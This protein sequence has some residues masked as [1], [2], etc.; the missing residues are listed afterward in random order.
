MLHYNYTITRTWR[1]TDV[2]GNYSECDQII[3]V[4]DITKPVITCPAPVTVNCQD[5]HTSASTGVATA[6]DNCAG[7][8]NIAITQSDVSTQ[9]ADINSAGHYNYTITR[10]WRA[11]DVAGNYSECDQ[12]IKVQ[13][14]TKPV[15]ITTPSNVLTNNDA[16]ICGAVVSFAATASDNC[17]PVAITYSKNPGTVF[18]VGTTS[19][20][21]TATDVSG[22]VLTATFEVTVTDNEKP[23]IITVNKIQ[24][25][26]VGDCG[27]FV[28]V[29]VPVTGDNCQV[30]TLVNNYNS[31]SNAS[32]H[33]PVGTTTINWTVT[34]IHGNINTAT[35]TVIVNDT[36]K[37]I[38]KAPGAYSVPSDPGLCGA[39]IASIGTPVTSDNC[40]VASITNNH[41]STF[42]PVGTTIVIWTV[43]DIHGN[44]TDTATQRIRVIDN[45]L[46]KITV[47]N[48]SVNSDLNV[49]GATIQPATPVTSDNCGV[50]TV[51]SDHP[52]TFYPVGTTLV[53]WTVTDIHGLHASVVQTIIVVDRQAP[54]AI[55]KNITVNLDGAGKVT[56]AAADVNNGSND[57]CG[58][59]SMTVSPSMFSCS[60]IGNNTVTLTVTDVNGNVSYK[61]AV[62]TVQDKLGPVPTLTTLPTV[63]GQCSARIL[64]ANNW[65]WWYSGDDDDD[66]DDSYFGYYLMN[67][68]TATDNCSG[69]IRG[70]TTDPLNYYV[71]GT[72]TIHWKFTDSYGNTTI[73]EQTVIVKDNQAP[74]PWLTSLP[75]VTGQC[76]VDLSNGYDGDDDDYEEDHD[77]D[78]EGDNDH[79]HWNKHHS[80]APWAWDNCAGWIRGTTTDPLTYATQGTYIIH[81]KFDDGHGNI[82]IQN[83]T[84]IVKDVTAPKAIVKNLP[85]ISGQC[86]VTVTTIPTAKDDCIGIVNGTTTSPLTYSAQGTYTIV[87]K[88]TDGRG[89][90]STQNQTVV[91]DDDNTAPV[92]QVTSLP[93]ITGECSATV[94]TV[95]KA[96]DNCKGI[97]SGTTTDALTYSREGTYTIHWTYNDG[98][99]NTST[100][101]QTVVINDVT[102]PVP[103]VTTLPTITAECSATVS[104]PKANDNCAGVITGTTGDAVTYSKQGTYTIHWTY[105]DGNG[106]TS[107]QNQTVIIKDVTAPVITVPAN[108][109]ISCS[110][111]F[112]YIHHRNSYCNR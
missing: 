55:T 22:N 40:G 97:I 52:S 53:T 28:S 4:H 108:T 24:S 89:N 2:A 103:Q 57:A 107:T 105:N 17:G 7:T 61:T 27:A 60:N 81:W 92:P 80:A 39:T 79:D 15:I 84:V 51:V 10:T 59:R 34:D 64:L 11:T 93:T 77:C 41:P 110:S 49:C 72:Y 43:T 100:Q 86:S 26:D 18:P 14:I 75:T 33:Y 21:V 109:T 104:A 58:I 94:T 36:E 45:E 1:A 68:P 23:T 13:D 111:Q 19:V 65:G 25:N 31:T 47:N 30:A 96:N 35:Q 29:P 9:V 38:V 98:N 101:N 54:N 16:G 87:W 76:S 66:D 83:Q 32:G 67:I 48:I 12:I 62:V 91:V 8:T 82:T 70:T 78:H 71:Q 56:I 74:R 50:A 37:P 99:G 85:T 46:P 88:Y 69:L 63:T 102:A 95:P 3:T 20:T 73:Q 44:V 6:T 90:T 42:Y 112:E 5:N 106:N